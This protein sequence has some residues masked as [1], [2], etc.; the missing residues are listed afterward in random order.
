MQPSEF[1]AQAIEA[2]HGAAAR[3]IDVYPVTLMRDGRIAWQ[4]LVYIFSLTGHASADRAYGLLRGPAGSNEI[5][6]A[7][8]LHQS[9]IR[10]PEDAVRAFMTLE[11]RRRGNGGEGTFQQ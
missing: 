7:T 5:R 3:L 11:T 2:E 10:S 4:T 9:R 1:L 8:Y 6:T